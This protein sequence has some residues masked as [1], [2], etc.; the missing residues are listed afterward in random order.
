MKDTGRIDAGIEV[1]QHPRT[2]S[3]LVNIAIDMIRKKT[4]I[5]HPAGVVDIGPTLDREVA[6]LGKTGIHTLAVTIDAI[7]AVPIHPHGRG[8]GRGRDLRERGKVDGKETGTVNAAASIAPVIANHLENIP[9]LARNRPPH[10][11]S[12]TDMTQTLWRIWLGLFPR[13]QTAS[14]RMY[15]SVPAA[16]VL[17]DPMPATSTRISPPTMIPHWTFN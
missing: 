1:V 8:R 16:E 15:Q 10:L 2:G 5:D 13:R 6:H 3:V 12:R 11:P 9:P 17:T 4:V 14:M 7:D